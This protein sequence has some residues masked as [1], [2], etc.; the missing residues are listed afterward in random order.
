MDPTFGAQNML[1][2]MQATMTLH[3]SLTMYILVEFDE[4]ALFL[5]PYN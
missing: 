4:L 2:T 1:A 5:S 3:K